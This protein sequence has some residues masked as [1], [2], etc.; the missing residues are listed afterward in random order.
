MDVFISI[1]ALGMLVIMIAIFILG[2]GFI[3]FEVKS[4]F[5]DKRQREETRIARAEYLACL[6]EEYE[7]CE[8]ISEREA[9][10]KRVFRH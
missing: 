4:H 5:R 9:F 7:A 6:T 3:I 8:S 2:A 1:L 10:R